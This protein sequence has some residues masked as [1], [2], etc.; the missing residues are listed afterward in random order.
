M[1]ANFFKARQLQKLFNHNF[2]LMLFKSNH[3]NEAISVS[4]L[5]MLLFIHS[6]KLL[7][8]HSYNQFSSKG[9]CKSECGNSKN[10]EIE[11]IASDCNVCNYQ[12]SKDA[13]DLVY[14][15]SIVCDP[16][17]KVFNTRLIA[18]H[19]FSLPSTFENRGP[20]SSFSFSQTN[21]SFETR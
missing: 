19:K 10:R 15:A 13:D 9:D 14:P 6:I 7:H 16:E 18:F 17:Q 20:P 8:T 2:A 5:V 21:D 4:L 3:I 12:L 1:V 11:K